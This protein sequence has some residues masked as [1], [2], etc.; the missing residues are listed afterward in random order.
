MAA[1]RRYNRSIHQA[2]PRRQAAIVRLEVL[3]ER[4]LLATD[5]WISSSS[6]SWNDASDWSTGV[7]PQP[8]DAVVIDVAGA[9]PTVTFMSGV[10]GAYQSVTVNDTL[11]VAS[12]FL[13]TDAGTITGTLTL[14]GGEIDGS[15]TLA[16]TTDWTQ[17]GFGGSG[18]VVNTGTINL[19]GASQGYVSTSA[20]LDNQGQFNLSGTL[21]GSGTLTNSAG[22]RS[23]SC[24]R[25]RSTVRPSRTPERSRNPRQ[26]PGR[27]QITRHSAISRERSRFPPGRSIS[28]PVGPVPM[29]H[30]RWQPVRPWR[31]PAIPTGKG[32]TAAR[33]R[34]AG[35]RQR[36]VHFIQCEWS[37]V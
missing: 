32:P 25:V 37:H 19:A 22:R 12:G 34:L 6:G 4:R 9:D 14:D 30:S 21:G 16:G 27:S 1:D 11:E 36:S 7:V 23:T 29:P 33:A 20:T 10:S 26:E 8:G 35:V 3:E 2:R 13:G 31:S 5:S 15:I 28:I 24:P 18:T 17:G